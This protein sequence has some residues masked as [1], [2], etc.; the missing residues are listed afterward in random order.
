MTE[1]EMVSKHSVSVIMYY[2][3]YEFFFRDNSAVV[4]VPVEMQGYFTAVADRLWHL[5]YNIVSCPLSQQHMYLDPM[6][7][8]LYKLHFSL[9][10]QWL[11]ETRRW[12]GL[13]GGMP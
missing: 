4:S 5:Q 8:T 2:F 6:T 12:Y 7:K 13:L 9:D 10:T 11:T 3:M 1:R